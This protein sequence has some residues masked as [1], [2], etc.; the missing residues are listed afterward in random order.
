MQN[1]GLEAQI[2]PVVVPGSRSSIA[3]CAQISCKLTDTPS[4]GFLGAA[5]PGGWKKI[6]SSLASV[7]TG[8]EDAYRTQDSAW[9]LA[10]G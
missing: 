2:E 9:A 10:S 1:S 6:Q 8:I 3:D 5:H 7:F 4:G